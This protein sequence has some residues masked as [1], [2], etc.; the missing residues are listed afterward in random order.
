M[1]RHFDE[2]LQKVKKNLLEM[3]SLVDESIT[4]ALEALKNR[5]LKMAS[6]VK[7]IDH[8]IDRFEIAIED[9]CIELI[10]RHQPVGTDLRFLI[11]VIKMN[12]DMERMG[13]HAVNIAGS[14]AFLIEQPRIKPVS[15]I[16]SMVVEV[17]KMLNDS[18]KSFMNNDAEMAQQVCERDNVVDEMRDETMRILLTYMLEQPDKIGSAIPLLLVAKNLERIADLTTNIC[19][20]VIYIAQAR[21]IKH[22]AEE[23]K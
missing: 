18:V 19:E 13:D 17:K 4:K 20:D 2:E 8:R 11:G 10:A 5:D 3:A 12:N 15:N 9:Q 7:E 22:H 21:V 6:E 23:Q 1:D 16:W 14:V